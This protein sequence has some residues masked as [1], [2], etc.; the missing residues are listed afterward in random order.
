MIIDC[1]TCVKSDVCR[2]YPLVFALRNK[3]RGLTIRDLQAECE[4]DM[5]TLSAAYGIQV[6]ITCEHHHNQ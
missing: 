4:L 3:A 2:Q 6:K 5:K 1:S